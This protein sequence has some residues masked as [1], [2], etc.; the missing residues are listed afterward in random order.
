[1]NR[2][3]LLICLLMCASTLNA[4][5]VTPGGSLLFWNFWY[6]N[7][8]FNA[9]T[10]DGDNWYFLFGNVTVEAKWDD[11]M[12]FFINPAALGVYGMHPCLACGVES[13]TVTLH[14]M[15]MDLHNVFNTPLSLRAGKFR[16]M[17][18]DAFV[19]WDGGAE[20]VTGAKANIATDMLDLDILALRIAEYGGPGF[21]SAG[22]QPD[23][24]E[25]GVPPDQ[26]LYGGHATLSFL[27]DMF[28]INGYFYDLKWGDDSPMWVGGRLAGEIS[29]LEPKAE[30]V[31]MMGDNGADTAIDY[32][33]MAYTAQLKYGIPVAPVKL[34]G[35]YVYFSGDDDLTDT[36]DKAYS[37][38]FESVYMYDGAA[39]NGFL[40]FGPA[41]LILTGGFCP[42]PTNMN[43][44]NGNIEF[45]PGD[46]TIR[47]DFFMYK[48][49][50]VPDGVDQ[51]MGNE[52]SVVLK[53][54]YRGD[55]T[56]G[57]SA[58]YFMPGAYY[59]DDLDPL[60][61]GVFFFNK[62]F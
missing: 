57:A 49:N 33:G 59:G 47:G 45:T 48:M 52:I 54:D 20:G 21:I 16:I 46:L 27:E 61:G 15:Y 1:M 32:K 35:G 2:L 56:F 41:H 3:A 39:A 12:T 42:N 37:N 34:G 10:E 14:Q 53:Y 24:L 5:E 8:D 4:V 7:A 28:E 18:D 31:M 17:Y 36:E 38:V 19:L 6:N 30:F 23:T 44:I 43:V 50:E 60:M 25:V 62:S 58:G 13:Q 29:G 11:H 40:G 55:I 51:A 9:D 26:N 22:P